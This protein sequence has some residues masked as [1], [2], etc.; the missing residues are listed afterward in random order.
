MAR[1]T[2][3]IAC[4]AAATALALPVGADT[5]RDMLET[6]AEALGIDIAA[7]DHVAAIA[8]P[9]RVAAI[10]A[11][12]RVAAMV[13][14][15]RVAAAAAPDRITAAAAP[16]RIALPAPGDPF[17]PA[18]EAAAPPRRLVLA[19]TP[20]AR[21]ELGDMRAGFALPGGISLA[22]GFDIETRIAGMPVQRLSLPLTE[23]GSGA[24]LVRIVEGA[25]VR[26]VPAGGGPIVA[27]GV[28]DAGATRVLTVLDR[29]ITSVVQNSRDGQV[30][31]RSASFQV[32]ISGMRRMLDA[33]GTRRMMDR[34]LDAHS[35]RRR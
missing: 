1:T 33:A 18:P 35:G 9:D 10:A 27:D 16:D 22:F 4:A 11:P 25:T 2:L 6:Y 31:Q 14:A 29:G 26:S 5:G 15:D 32:D 19:A 7:P 28:F 8:A 17:A 30:V 24:A 20:V 34:T 23:I 3:A 21:E 12:D 13:P